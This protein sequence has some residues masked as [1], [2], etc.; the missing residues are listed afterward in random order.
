MDPLLDR[1]I[2]MHEILERHK[3][4]VAAPAVAK[5]RGLTKA[6]AEEQKEEPLEGAHRYASPAIDKDE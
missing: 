3:M 1:F 4:C 6:L 5:L 2:P